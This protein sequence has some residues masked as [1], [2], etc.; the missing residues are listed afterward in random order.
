MSSILPIEC[1]FCQHVNP[2]GAIFCN[3]CGTQLNMQPC[4]ACG[5]IDARDARNCHKCGAE[6][7]LPAMPEHD[8]VPA[9]AIQAQQPALDSAALA[10]RQTAQPDHPLP[11]GSAAAAAGSRRRWPVAAAALVAAL[12]AL[13][14]F[15]YFHS[16]QPQRVVQK[17]RLEQ[18]M[19]DATGTPRSAGPSQ[20]SM[21]AQQPDRALTPTGAPTEP[22]SENGGVDKPATFAQ[23][24]ADAAPPARQMPA[25]AAGVEVRQ[26]AP[27][28][29]ECSQAVATLG[30]CNPDAKRENQ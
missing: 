27:Q 23:S 20:L 21:A 26:D 19:P 13:L 5:A 4:E 7:P 14:G 9:L 16:S 12:I 1:L 28:S 25:A 8:P 29:R 17:Q 11:S 30:L 2:P 24:D 18:A 10:A 3:A 15:Y 22:A 6:F